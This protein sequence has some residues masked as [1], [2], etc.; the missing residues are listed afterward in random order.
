VTIPDANLVFNG[1]V[2]SGEIQLNV[3]IPDNAPTG[4]AVPLVLTIGAA[5]SRAGVTIAI[6]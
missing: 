6:K 3:L 4:G 2:Y 5:S 1:L